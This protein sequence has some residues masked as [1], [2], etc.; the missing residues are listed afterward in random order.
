MELKE[1][2]ALLHKQSEK[3]RNKL[4]GTG[5]GSGSGG[6]SGNTG[7][8]S[9]GA[10]G[11]GGS[12]NQAK[13][14]SSDK[15]KRVETP[16][17]P[18]IVRSQ[19]FG[20]AKQQAN[21]HGLKIPQG[22]EKEFADFL[23]VACEEM[24]S[25]ILNDMVMYSRHRRRTIKS[26]NSTRSEISKALRDQAVKQKELEEKRLNKK[27][28]LGIEVADG[29]NKPKAEELS[30][31]AANA[32]AAMMTSGR[33]KTYSWMTG[34]GGAGGGGSSSLGSGFSS[35]MS[36]SSSLSGSRGS[37]KDSKGVRYR[38]ARQEEVFSVRDFVKAL[39]NRRRG[40]D[41]T[42]VKSYAKL[43]DMYR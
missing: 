2:E 32:T 33:T 16:M 37:D 34:G 21:A 29:K 39:E 19:V 26:S 10:G 17:A 6:G 22:Q 35:S 41:K 12:G 14:G 1:E 27:I 23:S 38:E 25:P 40:A 7:S 8:G 24:L 20:Y 42:L 30:H 4:L 3:H 5:G 11:T 13:D 9:G 28:Q 31:R 36:G 15:N 43:K 18:L